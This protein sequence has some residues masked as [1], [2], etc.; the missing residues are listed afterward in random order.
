MPLPSIKYVKRVHVLF[1]CS[2]QFFFTDR[3]TLA[4]CEFLTDKPSTIKNIMTK[5]EQA[6]N[7]PLTSVVE[8]E[9]SS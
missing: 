4:R 9:C 7:K 1:S 3:A 8:N 5:I 6:E 2:W